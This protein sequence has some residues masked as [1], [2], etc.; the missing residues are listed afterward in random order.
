[1]DFWINE[2]DDWKDERLH[3][4]GI[5][6]SNAY[7]DEIRD[8]QLID[9]GRWLNSVDYVKDGNEVRA[10]TPIGDPPYPYFL[11]VGF[12]HHISG[13]I[14]GPYRPLTKA[15]AASEGPLRLIW[16]QPIR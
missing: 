11:E 7:K 6:L 5:Q 1:M 15:A 4:S 3:M 9:T 13:E 14:V 12:R 16:Q 2:I 8:A 10:G